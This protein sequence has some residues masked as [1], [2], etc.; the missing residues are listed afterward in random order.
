MPV[1]LLLY[2]DESPEIITSISLA[3]VFFWQDR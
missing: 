3:V 2:P 1:L